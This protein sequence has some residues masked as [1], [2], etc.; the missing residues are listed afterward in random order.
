MINI[1][2]DLG[3][4]SY[5]IIIGHKS[6]PELGARLK[7]L[8]LG[9]DAVIITNPVVRQLHG[10]ALSTSLKKGG[11]T[12]KFFEVPDGEESKSAAQAFNLINRSPAIT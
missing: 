3:E 10:R 8:G 4:N 9:D 7:T 5:E 11:F 6:L 12:I 1:K 2:V